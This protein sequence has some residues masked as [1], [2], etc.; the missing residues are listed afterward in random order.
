[1]N[2][3]ISLAELQRKVL[4]HEGLGFTEIRQSAS[5]GNSKYV[6]DNGSFATEV[7]GKKDIYVG[8]NPRAT[9]KG[10]GKNGGI[11]ANDI[12]F[13]TCL[14]IDIDPVRA[15]SEPSSDLQHTEACNIGRQMCADFP[16]AFA[17]SSG[18]GCHIYFPIEPIKVENVQALTKSIQTWMMNIKTKYGTNTQK[19]DHIFDLPR[20]I[21]CWGTHNTKSNRTCEPIT[22]IKEGYRFNLPLSQVPETLPKDQTQEQASETEARFERLVLTSPALRA[23]VQGTATFESRSEA[24]YAFI[25]HLAQAHFSRTEIKSLMDKNPL[26]KDREDDVD[27]ILDKVKSNSGFD[28]YSLVHLGDRYKRSLDNRKM[29]LRT[30]FNKLDE[31]ISGLKAQ[32]VY[33][34]AARPTNGKTTLMTQMLD[35][36]V[37]TEKQ[38][39]LCFP[40]EVGA[41]PI[42]DKIICRR[43]QVNLKRFQ[44]GTFIGQDR[45]KID[46]AFESIKNL[47]LIIAEDFGLTVQKIEDKIR[48]VAPSVVAIDYINA[49][50]Y[51]KGGES[52]EI[53]YVTRKIKEL[54]GDYD[55]P[56]L[57][58]AQLRR[59][60]GKLDLSSLKGSGA[61]EELCDVVSFLYE[62]G[63][64]FDATNDGHG[65]CTKSVLDVMKSKYSATG[66]IDLKFYRSICEFK[67]S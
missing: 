63:D 3:T 4:G 8:I 35:Q 37:S 24:N 43:S 15:K 23:I 49:M 30:G 50:K 18:S 32:K 46:Q 53:A 40:T 42:I 44:N 27:R 28:S 48:K 7:N 41:E 55:L 58:F 19:I 33:L 29:G 64:K 25:M 10:T 61:L 54:A 1:M 16:G 6:K 22:E 39:A 65:Y 36:L 59:G 52:N 45:V 26:G 57:L 34:F 9:D 13:V 11:C 56:I 47:P 67:E 17:V 66:P 14:V 21:R 60:D 12:S 62:I 20:V 2:E 38:V 51:E 31:M 5:W